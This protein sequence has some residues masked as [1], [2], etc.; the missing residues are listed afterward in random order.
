MENNTYYGCLENIDLRKISIENIEYLIA[1]NV[2]EEYFPDED[3]DTDCY[4][5]PTHLLEDEYTFNNRYFICNNDLITKEYLSHFYKRIERETNPFFKKKHLIIKQRLKSILTVEEK[6]EET[7]KIYKEET[8]LIEEKNYANFENYS[9]RKKNKDSK[10]SIIGFMRLF[11]KITIHQIIDKKHDLYTYIPSQN[12][13]YYLQN[14]KGFESYLFHLI[15]NA[16]KNNL[17]NKE[18]EDSDYEILIYWSN[19]YVQYTI[20]KRLK[21]FQNKLIKSIQEQKKP[22]KRTTTNH[23]FQVLFIDCFRKS[24]VEKSIPENKII[25]YFFIL[26]NNTFSDKEL[27]LSLFKELVFL[28]KNIYE[29]LNQT[30]LGKYIS[31]ITGSD[32]VGLR[33]NS[34]VILKKP[35]NYSKTQKELFKNVSNIRSDIYTKINAIG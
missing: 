23:L 29:N 19:F 12:I 8:L 22:N 3:E 4:L 21:D 30:D 6:I 18:K 5:S 17:T 14:P 31:D 10:E 16:D 32:E 20:L 34:A 2:L 26:T 25:N 15:I 13:R 11:Y 28:D 24:V 7:K 35:N 9:S 1:K 27:Q 33:K